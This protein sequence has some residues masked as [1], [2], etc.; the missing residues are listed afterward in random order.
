M[1]ASNYTVKE[2]TNYSLFKF[3]KGNR[4]VNPFNLK[5]ITESM[6]VRC[7]F[8]PILVN[9]DMEI[10]DGQH[11]FLA[12][13]ELNLPVYFIEVPEYGLN[14][15]HILN[16]NSSN[17][18]RED[19]LSGY[20]DMGN[21]TYIQFKEFMS[22]YPSLSIN[23]SLCIIGINKDGRKQDDRKGTKYFETGNLVIPD[24]EYS[25]RIADKIMDYCSI[26]KNYNRISFVLALTKVICHKNYNHEEMMSR[27]NR[28]K[29][30]ITDQINANNYVLL[31]E[32]IFNYHR[33]Q[34]VSLRY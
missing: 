9:P 34:K 30:L 15:V 10:I 26:Y 11:R 1:K 19:Y 33:R 12:Q 14:E 28:R 23:S 3:M 29:E 25:C 21:R 27:L 18:K 20:V 16:T 4:S 24:Y 31:L 17:W 32:E 13:K 2:T 5:R 6:K 8:S 7:L 22:K